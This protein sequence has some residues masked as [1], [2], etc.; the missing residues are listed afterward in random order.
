MVSWLA[1]RNDNPNYGAL[2]DYVLPKGQVVFGPAQV[3]N[4]INQKEEVSRDFSLFNQQGTNVVQGNLL[5][6][7]IGD[8]FLYF[9]PIYL[10]ATGT[11]SLPELKRVILVDSE[12]VVY[13]DTLP[14]AIN[15][16][17][18]QGTQPVSTPT[19]TPS[20]APGGSPVANLVKQANDHYNAAQDALKRGDFSTYAQEMQTVG[21]ILQQLQ[22][23]T[24]GTSPTPSPSPSKTP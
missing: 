7:P 4:R 11:Q 18:G 15:A 23:L 3:A 21:K 8:S 17:V 24:G 12:K 13:T 20:P 22:Q 1:A 19:P 5:V 9:E 10:R 6:V 14:S 16:L 2:V